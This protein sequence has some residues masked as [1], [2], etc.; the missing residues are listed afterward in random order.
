MVGG[1]TGAVADTVP[2]AEAGRPPKVPWDRGAVISAAAPGVSRGKE[3]LGQTK[4]VLPILSWETGTFVWHC[5][6]QSSIMAALS[7]EGER[8]GKTV[9]MVSLLQ[10]T[11]GRPR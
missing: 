7:Q 2:R 11:S 8:G 6:Q 10:I 5:G 4:S 9:S 1:S 3:H